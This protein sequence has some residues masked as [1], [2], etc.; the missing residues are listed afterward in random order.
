[1]LDGHIPRLDR[2]AE[3]CD[4]LGLEFYIGP[5]RPESIDPPERLAEW[6]PVAADS[7]AGVLVTPWPVPV[8]ALGKEFRSDT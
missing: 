1:M 6:Q 8:G 5:P 3:I 4:A 7:D 2:A